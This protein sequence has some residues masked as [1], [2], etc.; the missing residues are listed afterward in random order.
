[1]WKRF[2]GEGILGRNAACGLI[3]RGTSEA[4][5]FLTMDSPSGRFIIAFQIK[6]YQKLFTNRGFSHGHALVFALFCN[7]R[8]R[9]VLHKRASL[10]ADLS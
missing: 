10:P 6:E 5:G 3:V 1:M 9:E 7:K 4:G 2:A 8:K